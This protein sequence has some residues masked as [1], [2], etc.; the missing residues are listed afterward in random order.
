[1]LFHTLVITLF[2]ICKD[3][4]MRFLMGSYLIPKK[5]HQ[6]FNMYL[7]Y[8]LEMSALYDHCIQMQDGE[9]IILEDSDL[10]AVVNCL[11]ITSDYK[12]R[13]IWVQEQV[14]EKFLWLIKRYYHSITNIPID[15]FYSLKD[16]QLN[17]CQSPS[18]KI[19]SIWSENIVAVKNLALFFN[20]HMTF[21]NTYM[22]FFGGIVIWPPTDCDFT[23]ILFSIRNNK[24]PDVTHSVNVIHLSRTV[25][26]N[27]TSIYNL[28]YDGTWQKP[29]KHK[30]WK[31]NGSLWAN[32]TNDDILR[33]YESAKKGFETW[34]IK[35]I[36]TR[37]QILSKF[38]SI[39]KDNGK[40]GLAAVVD[41]CLKCPYLYE[42]ITGF[43][44]TKIEVIHTRIPIGVTILREENENVFFFRLIQ[45]LIAGNSVIVMFSP[46]FYNLIPHYDTFSICGVPPGVINLLSHE[47]ANMLEM[48]LCSGAYT[49][50]AKKYFLKCN[51]I[52]TYILQ[53]KQLTIPKQIVLQV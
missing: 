48:R 8:I 19:L 15:T 23:R 34:S 37:I 12:L 49:D 4:D 24:F 26:K 18:M 40:L 36:K 5:P 41:R 45:T 11:R 32:A 44:N 13:K 25:E 1:M 51:S 9:M 20:M 43:R 53:Y 29:T 10:Y 28:F 39:L 47:D 22:D 46:N 42:S 2:T 16:V 3:A 7:E 52:E 21:I 35:S 31:Y 30:Y 14:K 38:V 27:A 17:I 50:Y 33:C 6:T